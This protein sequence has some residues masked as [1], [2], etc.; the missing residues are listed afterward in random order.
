[1]YGNTPPSYINFKLVVE[2][3]HR[4]EVIL[5]ISKDI[6]GTGAMLFPLM[7]PKLVVGAAAIHL[8]MVVVIMV[9]VPVGTLVILLFFLM[10]VVVVVMIILVV[11]IIIMLLM[12]PFMMLLMV[13]FMMLVIVVMVMGCIAVLLVVHVCCMLM[14]FIVI[15]VVVMTAPIPVLVAPLMIV[16]PLLTIT[17][18]T[19]MAALAKQGAPRGTCDRPRQQ[20]MCT[21]YDALCPRGAAHASIFCSS[22][23]IGAVVPVALVLD[24]GCVT[25]PVMGELWD[26]V[27]DFLD[28]KGVVTVTA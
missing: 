13:P 1:M 3:E 8:V 6:Q 5:F 26:Q 24:A 4:L 20:V 17:I 2:L 15:V 25:E 12:V 16:M 22:N 23:I 27:D 11:I 10:V 19:T 7:L 14:F 28:A 18:P 9:V 21:L